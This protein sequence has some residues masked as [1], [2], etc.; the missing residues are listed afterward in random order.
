M[1]E[2]VKALVHTF[3]VGD[4][5][6]PE[7]YAAEPLLKWQNS[8]EGKWVMKHAV[9]Q[10]VWHRHTNYDAYVYAYGITAKFKPAD[11][12]YWKLKFK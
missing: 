7:I 9:E 12:T 10:P 8:E 2:F 4:V 5:E 3:T 6:D 11:F 1:T